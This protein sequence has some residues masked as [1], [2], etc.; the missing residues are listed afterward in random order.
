MWT[1]CACLCIGLEPAQEFSFRGLREGC[2]GAHRS[3]TSERRPR[4]LPARELSRERVGFVGEVLGKDEV[5]LA[6]RILR[7]ADE[8][9]RLVVLRACVR[10]QPCV[11]DT[12]EIGHGPAEQ[13]P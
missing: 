12:I 3:T 11:V 7:L 9:A 6:Q 1:S 8:P 2:A 5:L 4:G 10:I 13:R